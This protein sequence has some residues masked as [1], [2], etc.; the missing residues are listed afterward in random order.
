MKHVHCDLIK[1]WA[2]GAEIQV[3]CDPLHKWIDTRHPE[4]DYRNQYRI[5]P[6]IKT[7]IPYRRWAYEHYLLGVRVG[8]VLNKEGYSTPEET[9]KNP[10][11]IKWID[12]TWTT[13]EIEM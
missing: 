10:N 7:T 8:I 3:Y 4:W 1:A 6:V 11:F 12:T 9:E 2:D 13:H 5:K